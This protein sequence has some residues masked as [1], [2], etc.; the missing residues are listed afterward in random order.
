MLSGRVFRA[1]MGV[2][3]SA[4]MQSDDHLVLS[5]PEWRELL[6]AELVASGFGQDSAGVIARGVVERLVRGY[7]TGRLHP[8]PPVTHPLDEAA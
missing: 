4:R 3:V 1:V 5:P 8:D 2:L 7:L 6:R